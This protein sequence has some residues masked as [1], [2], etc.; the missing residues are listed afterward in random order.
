VLGAVQAAAK[1][2]LKGTATG[3]STKTK[4]NMMTSVVFVSAGID[5][6]RIKI[7]LP[8]ADL[9]MLSSLRLQS[10]IAST[11]FKYEHFLWISSILTIKMYDLRLIRL[12][13]S[14]SL[15]SG[16]LTVML[17]ALVLGYNSWLYL[18]EE[19][20]FYDYLFGYNGLK[21][22]VWQHSQAITT[23]QGAFFNSPVVYY[24]LVVIAAAIAGVMTYSLL[25]LASLVSHSL[26]EG[27]HS[28]QSE[29]KT[30][31]MVAVEL[32][33]RLGL[34][35][36]SLLCWGFY[37]GFFI[38]IIIPFVFVLNRLGIDYIHGSRSIGWLACLG[39]LFILILSLHL[40]IIFLRLVFLR[41]RVFGGDHAIAVAEA[42]IDS[43]DARES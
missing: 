12:L 23:W 6:C 41:P 20:L 42:E 38:S 33:T 13:L 34:R 7:V 27:W 26:K 14:P 5:Q 19:Q 39:A 9:L 21:T 28:L 8:C 10:K 29:G 36:L 22:Y 30:A 32:L 40:H 11:F 24:A 43:H 15:F 35:I 17:C 25:Q 3:P 4:T 31:R 37:I 18:S 1:T 2:L 16:G